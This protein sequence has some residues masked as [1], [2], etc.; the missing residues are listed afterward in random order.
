[1]LAGIYVN[2]D[3][4]AGFAAAKRLIS[5]FEKEGIP[6]VVHD[7]ARI[8]GQTAHFGDDCMPRPDVIV[9]LGGDGTILSAVAFA[10]AKSI[11]VLGINLGNIGFLSSL[12]AARI[13]ECA[14]RLKRGDY[15]LSSRSM[16]ETTV[17]GKKLLALNE[18]AFCKK[19]IGRTVTL[20]VRVGSAVLSSFKSDGYLVSTPTGSTAYALS[21][22]GPVVSPNV[23]CNLLV[24]VSGHSLSA[25]PVVIGDDEIVD[26]TSDE[27]AC[28]IADGRTDAALATR[29]I[30]KKSDIDT[31]FVTMEETN[32]YAKL[33]RK[34][35]G[36]I[37]EGI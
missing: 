13:E 28:V 16:L 36:N 6:F 21:C 31:T 2:K 32:F 30:V 18:I 5:A 10:A 23:G 4:D 37:K 24:P 22:G 11:P 1:M 35:N 7:S 14:A 19:N 33:H 8:D 34:L 27:P 9:V 17:G 29:I 15:A 25:K 26:I 20:T 12:G 3:R